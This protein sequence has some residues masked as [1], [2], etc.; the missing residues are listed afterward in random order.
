MVKGG[1]HMAGKQKD[2]K[3]KTA[4]PE[5]GAKARSY[6]SAMAVAVNSNK[7]VDD[8]KQ[9]L[10][11]VP[12]AVCENDQNFHS[13]LRILLSE[14]DPIDVRLSALQS[15]QAASFS[16]IS[17]QSCR[18]DYIAALRK[19]STD[20]NPE[21][22]QRALGMLVRDKDGFAK[23]KLMEGLKDPQKALLPPEKAL[24]LLSYDIHS[25]AYEIARAMVE[26][27]P[28]ELARRE[29]L[30]LLAADGNSAPLFEKILRDQSEPEEIRQI[31][32]SA[33]NSL[34]PDKLQSVARDIVLDPSEPEA[35]RDTSLTALTQ[36]GD[37]EKLGADE[38]LL[39]RVNAIKGSSGAKAKKTAGGFLTKYEK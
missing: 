34:K 30:R 11:E 22:R 15:L 5:K 4:S 39:R 12:A 25:D 7:S 14:E 32:A 24:Q 27:P 17:F 35:I 2:K 36:F 9:A 33:L 37:A 19:V 31:S 8:R 6:K 18:T 20:P 28:N 29:A 21:L 38:E 26:N 23:R 13:I 10:F 3:K 1:K 16:V